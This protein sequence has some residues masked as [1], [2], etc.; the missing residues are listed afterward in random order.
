MDASGDLAVGY[1]VSSTTTFPSIRYAARLAGD[2]PGGLFQGENDNTPGFAIGNASQ[3]STGSRWGDYS[4]L[5][6]DPADDCTF[7]YTQQYYQTPNPPSCSSTTCWRT[8]IG[9]FLLPGC[10]SP[11]QTGTLQGTVTALAGGLPIQGAIVQTADGYAATTNASGF[12]TMAIP[13]GGYDATAF[14]A[15][16]AP[17]TV[18]AI[19]VVASSTTTQNF[20]LGSG[21]VGGTVTDSPPT[22]PIA[23]ATVTVSTG[24]TAI[25]NGAGN[26]NISLA[27]GT[28][29]LVASAPGYYSESA[30]GVLVGSSGV[31]PA[32]FALTASPQL[33]VVAS[34]VDDWH[35]GNGSESV[36]GDECFRLYLTLGNGA[37]VA[38]TGV[39]ATLATTTPGITVDVDT[40]AFQDIPASGNSEAL[41]PFELT[42]SPAFAG[43]TPIEFLL[44]VTTTTGTLDVPFVLST[45]GGAAVSFY[46]AGPVAIPD[47]SGVGASLTVPV[48]GFTATLSKVVVKLR[49]TH[50]YDG[51]LT[52]RV[53][54]PDGTLGTLAVQV[55]GAGAGFGTGACPSAVY[56]VFD[57]D[58]ATWILDGTA[59]FTGSYR[60]HL[61]LT[62]FAGKLA[63]NVNGDWEVRAI[64]LGPADVGTIDCAEIW[65]NGSLAGGSCSGIFR[66]DFESG[67][68][69]AVRWS[70]FVSP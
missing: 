4:A 60:P 27:P 3:T 50:T 57:D 18:T 35:G 20:Q 24:Q 31:T 65:L 9:S 41:T 26:Y 25:T 45:A 7:W 17:Q 58:A 48:S 40:A 21:S 36:D 52:L 54:S 12:Y 51:D 55:G 30:S 32:G 14:R 62:G 34:V 42:S 70:N 29:S 22:G 46:A 53:V 15:S 5:S 61:P 39:S 13:A 59:P 6:V 23:G 33:S 67:G 47:N 10:S 43:G 68:P 37:A 1:S 64:D 28:Y 44:T 38:A 66:D 19:S 16:F 2:P 8:R 56:T 69:V 63:A 49:I 11:T